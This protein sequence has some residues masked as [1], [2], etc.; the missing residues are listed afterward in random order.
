MNIL[1]VHPHD[2]FSQEEPWTVRIKN[3]AYEFKN[4]NHRV[5]LI[6]FPLNYDKSRDKFELNGIEFIPL[7]R[8]LGIRTYLK[9]IKVF[10]QIA[11]WTD[12][13]HFQKC[14]YHAA[15]PAVI[16]GYLMKKPIH[17]DWDDWEIKIF[18]DAAKQPRFIECFLAGLER[19]M[20]VFCD[21]V[22]VSS[23]RLKQECIKYGIAKQKIA[24]AP[25]GADLDLFYP[26]ISGTRIRERY[27]IDGPIVSY[28]GQLHSGQYAE[29]F[30][31]AAKIILS[32]VPELNFM[33]IGGGHRIDELKKLA[34][35]LELTDNMIFTGPVSHTE[36]PLYLAACD[37]AIA[38]FE[39][40]DITRCKSPLK[41]AEYLASGKAIV[42]S[43]VGEVKR[44]IG[45]AGI[46]T[47]PGDP[48]DLARGIFK[49]LDDEP[50]RKRLAIKAR[51]RAQEIYNWENTADN[52]LK[53]YKT[54]LNGSTMKETIDHRL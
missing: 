29:Q 54:S 35:S 46:L 48:Q 51:Q 5:K 45:G 19:F 44:M 31:R 38:C 43:D 22:S 9:N 10:C 41:I 25:V 11:K 34:A 6:Y 23:D 12:I 7:S 1:M 14:F 4:K 8:R 16:S 24:L 30:I 13:I 39:D 21:T 40:N 50:L 52:L 42:A 17:Y 28:L 26:D 49:L 20:P 33:V 3:I 32:Q 2:L 18:K 37:I 15:L 53:I 27:N 47:A 36:T